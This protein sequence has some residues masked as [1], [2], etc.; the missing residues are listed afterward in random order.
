[1]GMGDIGGGL[2]WIGSVDLHGGRPG[3]RGGQAWEGSMRR[4]TGKGDSWYGL[5]QQALEG[6]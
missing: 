1:M 3:M 5:K 4:E 6:E 2:V